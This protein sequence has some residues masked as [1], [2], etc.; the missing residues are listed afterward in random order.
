[1]GYVYWERCFYKASHPEPFPHETGLRTAALPTQSTPRCVQ[2]LKTGPMERLHVGRVTKPADHSP[3]VLLI[4]ERSAPASQTLPRSC[5][6]PTLQPDHA[7]RL[8]SSA[9]FHYMSRAGAD[10]Q[11]VS[12][13]F[14]GTVPQPS[15]RKAFTPAAC[16]ESCGLLTHTAAGHRS[17]QAHTRGKERQGAA[18]CSAGRPH[19]RAMQRAA[20]RSSSH[21]PEAPAGG[22][23]RS[24][25]PLGAA[26]EP[27]PARPRGAPLRPPPLPAVSGAVCGSAACGRPCTE[28]A[29]RPGPARPLPRPPRAAVPLA[30]PSSRLPRG[31]PRWRRGV[32]HNE[33]D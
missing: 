6:G 16:S 3:R 8:C 13:A 4:P 15:G 28:R 29:L 9:C 10:T 17:K 31:A 30:G 11:R 21:G 19:R 26:G 27:R 18:S 20:W 32:L 2:C 23:A 1:M 24:R 12:H 33:G 22:A 7:I 25:A 14:Q 5:V